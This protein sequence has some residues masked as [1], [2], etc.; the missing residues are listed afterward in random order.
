VTGAR[1]AGAILLSLAAA[2][3]V[4]A[5]A[6]GAQEQRQRSRAELETR[7][8]APDPRAAGQRFPELLNVRPVRTGPRT[9][10]FMVMV[11][12]PYDS[13]QRYASGWRVLTPDGRELAVHRLGR[14]HEREQ[15]FWRRQSDVRVPKGV[16]RVQL[17]ASDSRNG[18]GG[19]RLTLALP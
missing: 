10:D 2:T 5:C 7:A 1:A 4:G 14:S 17:E 11:S 19:R 6:D 3:A 8:T 12:A 15:P 13:P 9:Y 18:Y 16:Q